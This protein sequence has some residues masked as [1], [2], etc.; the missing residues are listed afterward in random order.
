MI[1]CRPFFARDDHQPAHRTLRHY[2]GLPGESASGRV[3]QKL[4]ATSRRLSPAAITSA[5]PILSPH[6]DLN[7]NS[8]YRQWRFD[9]HFGNRAFQK[10]VQVFQTGSLSSQWQKRNKQPPHGGGFM[11]DFE[12]TA[13][14][15]RLS[16]FFTRRRRTLESG[17]KSPPRELY[18]SAA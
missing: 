18:L 1:R 9:T 7:P 6:V 2:Q 3:L 12:L 17:C 11:P 10:T 13:Q 16:P 5:N 8:V 4:L 14:W 15:F